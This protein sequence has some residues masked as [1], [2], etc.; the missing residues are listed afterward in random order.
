M[1]FIIK[2][3]SY[4]Y[5]YACWSSIASHWSIP[6]NFTKIPFITF[7]F[8]EFI[9]NFEGDPDTDSEMFYYFILEILLSSWVPLPYGF[10][11]QYHLKRA[12]KKNCFAYLLSI[13][14][15]TVVYFVWSYS[16]H[17]F[18]TS[19]TQPWRE[20]VEHSAACVTQICCSYWLL[21]PLNYMGRRCN[22]RNHADA[23][24]FFK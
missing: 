22:W 8:K 17:K 2:F 9:M 3:N 20:K 16:N 21:L 5:Y 13:K 23:I 11:S 1:N 6:C 19:I 12:P 18:I 14:W 4:R 15:L 7:A 10:Q 24:I